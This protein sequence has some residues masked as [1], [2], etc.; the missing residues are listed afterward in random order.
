MPVS[1]NKYLPFIDY[2]HDAV[3]Y[4]VEW[5]VIECPTKSERGSVFSLK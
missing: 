2:T 4:N 3:K 1:A 5:R